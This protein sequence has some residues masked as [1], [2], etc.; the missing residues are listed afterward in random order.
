MAFLLLLDQLTLVTRLIFGKSSV[1]VLPPG[2]GEDGSVVLVLM[3]QLQQTGICFV[4]N[5]ERDENVFELTK[6]LAMGTRCE[7][8]RQKPSTRDSANGL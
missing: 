8:G 6:G 3:V 4:G 1:N 7:G 2:K 5:N